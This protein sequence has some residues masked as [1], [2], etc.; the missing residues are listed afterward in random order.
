[1][2]SYGSFLW[3]NRVLQW[4]SSQ[5]IKISHDNTANQMLRYL[6][7]EVFSALGSEIDRDCLAA[8]F[9]YRQCQQVEPYSDRDAM[10]WLDVTSDVGKL[11]AIGVSVEA[12]EYDFDYC[13]MLFLHELTHIAK[14]GEH[15]KVFHVY[16]D[17]LLSVYN[18]VTGS[19]MQN[20]Y[21]GL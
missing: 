3:E 12:L 17:Y 16:L 13:V 8:M 18:S 4:V 14:G 20:D 21:Q 9:T 2:N 5:G 11:Y 19:E 15:G 10:C 1:M 7:D 6:A